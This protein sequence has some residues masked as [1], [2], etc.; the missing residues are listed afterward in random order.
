MFIGIDYHQAYSVN[1][2]VDVQGESLV[3]LG[4]RVGSGC[5]YIHFLSSR[6][7]S[8]SVRDSSARGASIPFFSTSGSR[9]ARRWLS[10]SGP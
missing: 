8:A 9:S 3:K 6:Y 1:S 2:V 5:E 7:I 10:N 4:V